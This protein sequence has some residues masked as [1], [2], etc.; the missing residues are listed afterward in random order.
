MKRVFMVEV[1]YNEL[2]ENISNKCEV[3]QEVGLEIALENFMEGFKESKSIEG[4]FN[5]KVKEVGGSDV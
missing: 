4:D 5:I 3:L 1:E 2:K